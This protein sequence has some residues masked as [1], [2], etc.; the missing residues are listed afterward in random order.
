MCLSVFSVCCDLVINKPKCVCSV[1]SQEDMNSY[2]WRFERY[3]GLGDTSKRFF[4]GN[5]LDVYVLLQSEDIPDYDELKL[6]LL[7]I[8]DLS[9]NGFKHRFRSSKPGNGEKF[10][11]LYERLLCCLQDD[12]GWQTLLILIRMCLFFVLHDQFLYS[13]NRDLILFLKERTPKSI[14]DMQ[15]LADT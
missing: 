13:C 2:L 1:S 12:R 3:V 8:C 11:N 14:Q 7:K 6:A 9:E 4:K 15:D 5:A 10:V